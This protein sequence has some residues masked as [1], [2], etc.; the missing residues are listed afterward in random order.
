MKRSLEAHEDEKV[1]GQKGSSFDFPPEHQLLVIIYR[2]GYNLLIILSLFINLFAAVWSWHLPARTATR[3]RFGR[4]QSGCLRSSS[5]TGAFPFMDLIED[6][7]EQVIWSADQSSAVSLFLT[8]KALY[9]H[10]LAEAHLD[11]VR[12]AHR[13]S[14]LFAP[15]NDDLSNI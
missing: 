14:S 15:S 9:R 4:Q 12:Y 2:R 1:S 7:Q 11:D 13:F 8:C 5:Q 3:S 10:P 6:M